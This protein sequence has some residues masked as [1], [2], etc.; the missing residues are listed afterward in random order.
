[1]PLIQW[2][3][4]LWGS[5]IGQAMCLSST[6]SASAVGDHSARATGPASHPRDPHAKPQ[7]NDI[8]M[9]SLMHINI[10]RSIG[11]RLWG[12]RR[13]VH[14]GTPHHATGFRRSAHPHCNLQ[15][16][17]RACYFVSQC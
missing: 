12:F 14:P 10:L 16:K 9:V 13:P 7:C 15:G 5:W 8:I 6:H 17:R 3:N 11:L 4:V 2:Y 1:M